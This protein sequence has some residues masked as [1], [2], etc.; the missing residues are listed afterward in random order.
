MRL[1][2][3]HNLGADD[4]SRSGSLSLIIPKT[5]ACLRIK[6]YQNCSQSASRGLG[7]QMDG[8]RRFT[9]TTFLAHECYRVHV[10]L[11]PLAIKHHNTPALA[12]KCGFGNGRKVA[13]AQY[14]L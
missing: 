6:I 13:R 8:K 4:P 10:F 3:P 1:D 2:Q 7:C 11:W 9:S 12:R 5:G 14:Q